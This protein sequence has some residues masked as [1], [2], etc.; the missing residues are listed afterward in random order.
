MIVCCWDGGTGV[1]PVPL[2]PAPAFGR[3][4][5]TPLQVCSGRPWISMAA[6]AASASRPART[7]TPILEYWELSGHTMRAV[8]VPSPRSGRY[9]R[10]WVSAVPDA[11]ST[12]RSPSKTAEPGILTSPTS[13]VD[14]GPGSPGTA[15]VQAERALVPWELVAVT[16]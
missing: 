5:Q 6:W 15:A 16:V 3:T 14:Q 7:V 1:L 4:L 2:I 8:I 13:R 10:R 11:S 12:N 9:A